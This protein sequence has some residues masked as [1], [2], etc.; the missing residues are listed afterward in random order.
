MQ[1]PIACV[2]RAWRSFGRL[3]GSQPSAWF[4]A[5]SWD[6][7]KFMRP[8]PPHHLSPARAIHPAG[9]DPEARFS[10]PSHHSNAPIKPESQSNLSKIV[11]LMPSK[12]SFG[13]SFGA[14]TEFGRLARRNAII[15]SSDEGECDVV[16]DFGHRTA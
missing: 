12:G 11:A 9:Q 13:K 14:S 7:L 8:H 16:S 3:S 6:P 2:T 5:W 4:W 15:I 1:A 10:R